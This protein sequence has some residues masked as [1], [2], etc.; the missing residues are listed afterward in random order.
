MKPLVR[1]RPGFALAALVLVGLALLAVFAAP[2]A[3]HA[4]TPGYL[5]VTAG[6]YDTCAIQGLYG[7][8]GPVECWGNDY[9]GEATPP[10]GDFKQ[11][12]VGGYHVCG[13]QPYG[14]AQCWG[15]TKCYGSALKRAACT[16]GAD[17]RVRR[18]RNSSRSA[19]ARTTPAA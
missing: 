2:P 17:R 18:Q 5:Q 10:A 14:S 11:V 15:S 3:A 8:T 9:Y 12:T 16:C 6:L 4:E 7:D 13:L 19:P 1:I